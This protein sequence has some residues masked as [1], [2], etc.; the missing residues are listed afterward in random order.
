MSEPTR[1]AGNPSENEQPKETIESFVKRVEEATGLKLNRIPDAPPDDLLGGSIIERS[2]YGTLIFRDLSHQDADGNDIF[3]KAAIV[4]RSKE[5]LEA[6]P[7]ADG[8]MSHD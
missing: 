5:L 3:D 1:G 7:D 4:N 2:P 6:D 8:L